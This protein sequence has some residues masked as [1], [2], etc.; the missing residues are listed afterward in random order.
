VRP[1]PA[2]RPGGSAHDGLTVGRVLRS[3]RGHQRGI[4]ESLSKR[5]SKLA[6]HLGLLHL[7]EEAFRKALESVRTTEDRADDRTVGVGVAGC[8]HCRED[9]IL[10]LP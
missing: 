3:L 10:K 2:E 4:A 7:V 8:V 1:P 9:A 6:D 5:A